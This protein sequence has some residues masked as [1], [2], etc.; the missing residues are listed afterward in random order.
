MKIAALVTVACLVADPSSASPRTIAKECSMTP[1]HCAVMRV[2]E[3]YVAA[4]YPN[5]DTLKNP[6][7]VHDRGDT[8][9][10]GYE[11]PAETIGGT[12]VIIIEKKTLKVLR[13]FHT[14]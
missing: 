8:W 12:P 4:H 9:E 14:Q 11:L 13:S 2:A 5:F 7:F 3:R 10:V 6:P 1:M